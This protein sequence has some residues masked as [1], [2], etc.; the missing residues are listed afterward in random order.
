MCGIAGIAR[1]TGRPAPSADTLAS[2]VSTLHHRG[3][4][5][6][7]L[8]I[9]DGVGLGMRRLAVIDIEGGAQPVFNEDRSVRAV[10]NGEIYNF[11]QL[12]DELTRRGH[13]F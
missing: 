10:F 6:D 1:F 2:M 7:G 8:D 4:D 13:I 11:R 5:D 12:K 9:A 3:P